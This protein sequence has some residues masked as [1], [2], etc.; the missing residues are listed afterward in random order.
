MLLLLSQNQREHFAKIDYASITN[1]I[2]SFF[3][4]ELLQGP[5]TFQCKQNKST[6]KNYGGSK[7][8]LIV[9][10]EQQEKKKYILSISFELNIY[11][12]FPTFQ[13]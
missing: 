13:I 8:I 2:S 9:E 3:C 1:K 7:Y 10:E 6:T 4:L 5:Q 12:V 11:L